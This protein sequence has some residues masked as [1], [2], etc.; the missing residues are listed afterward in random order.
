MPNPR[1][2]PRAP[3]AA[4][5]AEHIVRR[6]IDD[7]FTGGRL[8]VCDEFIADELVEH[9]DYGPD[10][11]A[12]A[13]GVRAVVTSLRRAFSDFVLRIEDLVVAGD[14]VWTRNVASGTHDGPYLGHAPTGRTFEVQV[15]DV[16]RVVDGRVVEHWGVPDRLGVLLQ[17]GL[18]G[19]RR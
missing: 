5:T 6:L 3:L 15:F 16:L 11:P 1:S 17:L 7:A 10:H 12:G 9:Q 13:A 18:A 2:N 4:A 14:T 19:G 8:A